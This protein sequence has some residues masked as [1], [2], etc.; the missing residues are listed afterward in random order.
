MNLRLTA[1]IAALVC[2]GAC[3]G[4]PPQ[5]DTPAEQTSAF[6]ADTSTRLPG[7]TMNR[8][9]VPG[10]AAPGSSTVMLNPEHGQPGHSCAIAVGAPLN[11]SSQMQ[12]QPAPAQGLPMG[13]P[14]APANGGG[15][16]RLNPAHGQ[17]GHNCAIP[18]GQPL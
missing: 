2:L 13:S 17:P 9:S 18:V 1:S 10:Q 12:Q 3:S 15:T 5:L 8:V 11:G 4:P 6:N 14:S 16:A 7:D